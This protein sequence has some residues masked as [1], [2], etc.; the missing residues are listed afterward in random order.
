MAASVAARSASDAELATDIEG[1]GQ[2]IALTTA[3]RAH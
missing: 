2:E 3:T 1:R